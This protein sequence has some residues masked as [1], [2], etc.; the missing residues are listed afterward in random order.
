MVKNEKN[1]TTILAIFRAADPLREVLQDYTF[2]K[3]YGVIYYD[4]LFDALSRMPMIENAHITFI[5]LRPEELTSEGMTAFET[6]SGNENTHFVVW[7][8]KEER[9]A[10]AYHHLRPGKLHCVE[11]LIQL[12]ILLNT[13]KPALPAEKILSGKSPSS[14]RNRAEFRA[15]PL[16]DEELDA[17]LGVDL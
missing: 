11:N 14:C 13:I 7:L 16:S 2:C 17:L 5:V 6:L 8:G 4:H 12:D 1:N 9:F 15:E 3:G 10:A